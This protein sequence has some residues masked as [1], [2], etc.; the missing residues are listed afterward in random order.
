ML[1]RKQP[2][3]LPKSS[4]SNSYYFTMNDRAAANRI[5]LRQNRMAHASELLE[6]IAASGL[7]FIEVKLRRFFDNF[8]RP[9]STKVAPMIA[10]IGL[11][12]LLAGVMVYAWSEY[13]RAPVIAVLSML[14]ASA[15]LYFVWPPSH[16]TR[17]AALVGIGRG[18]DLI[19]YV[20]VVISLILLLNLHLKL[21][22]QAESENVRPHGVDRACRRDAY[23]SHKRC[24][25]ITAASH[26]S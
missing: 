22:S 13:R 6:Q 4:H 8:V 26:A 20:W 14:V 9:L 17:L 21:R 12:V 15:G 2:L 16:A 25:A 5:S 23:V 3:A 10:Q 7:A 18:V 19:I 11:S 1:K 24:T